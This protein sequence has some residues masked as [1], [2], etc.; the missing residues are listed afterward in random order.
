MCIPSPN[1]RP[2][3]PARH[4]VVSRQSL[5]AVCRFVAAVSQSAADVSQSAADVSQSAAAVSQTE[6]VVCQFVAAVYPIRAVAAR[7]CSSLALPP[8]VS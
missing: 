7:I 6:A 8:A 5:V 3:C 2:V 1:Y 4:A